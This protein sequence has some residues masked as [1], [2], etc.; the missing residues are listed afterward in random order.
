MTEPK[1]WYQFQG[2]KIGI[3]HGPKRVEVLNDLSLDIVVINYD[4]I[5]WAAPLLLRGHSFG[6]LLCDELTKL[7]STTSKRY[8]MLKP[9][10]DS[11]KFRWG[12]TG[13][14]ASNGL[15]DLFGQC[16]VLDSGATLGKYITHFRA[17][18]FHQLP[19]DQFR[20]YI[21]AEKSALLHE[22]LKPLAM[23][24][25]PEEWL[26]L[27]PFMVIPLPVELPKAVLDQYDF[28][29]EEFIMKLGDDTVTA[30]NAGVLTSKLR[31]LTGG[32][33]YDTNRIV[34]DVH[35]AKI[36]RLSLL[37]D[38][39]AG[40]PLLV[41]YQFSHEAERILKK[42]P[43]AL[44]LRGGM[45]GT[46]VEKVVTQWNSGNAPLLLVQPSAA[47]LG[48]NLQFGGSAICWFS[49]TYNLE[50]YIQ[51]NKRLHRQGQVQA[52][53]C[54]LLLATKTIDHRVGKILEKKNI[55]QDDLF[56]ALKL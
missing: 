1:K 56:A 15:I 8:K 38:E 22:R 34:V 5:E 20:Y 4:G 39:M 45:T 32:A 54:Y 50:E 46:A 11:F 19:H 27:P 33:L 44:V 36:D 3:A 29:E 37:I 49:L 31:Q 2:L 16:Y 7:K 43:D 26:D 41:A 47:A 28:L 9:C 6:V 14:P 25:D 12:L 10:L 24:V 42:Y 40:E 53:R 51:L 18:Y 35:T 23:F 13:T 48:L 52:V 17:K 21:N 30:S 55:T